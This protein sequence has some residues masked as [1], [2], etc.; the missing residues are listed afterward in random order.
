MGLKLYLIEQGVIDDWDTYD[1]AVVAAESMADARMM[2]PAD[3]EPIR[4]NERHP[5]WPGDPR[6]VECRLLGYAHDG[7]SA[8]VICSSFN[9]G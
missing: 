3:G 1:S 4:E 2:H 5:M 8:G 7:I 6:D 9:A